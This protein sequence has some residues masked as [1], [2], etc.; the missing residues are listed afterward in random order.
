[1]VSEGL[2]CYFMVDQHFILV[3]MEEAYAVHLLSSCSVQGELQINGMHDYMQSLYEVCEGGILI[4]SIS[5][6]KEI[7]A[8]TGEVI[9][10]QFGQ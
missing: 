3:L 4:I 9:C 2:L 1:M 7:E 8:P 6:G 5:Q 10:C